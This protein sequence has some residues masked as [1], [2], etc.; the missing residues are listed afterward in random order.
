MLQA[1]E[2]KDGYEDKNCITVMNVL[3]CL[4]KYIT[5]LG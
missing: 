4:A 2:G 1:N 5:V 3:Q